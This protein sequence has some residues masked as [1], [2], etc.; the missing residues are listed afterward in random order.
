MNQ[1]KR[2][3]VALFSGGLDSSLAVATVRAQGVEVVAFHLVHYFASCTFDGAADPEVCAA[4]EELGVPLYTEEAT[5]AM[6]EMLRAPAHGF[7]KNLNPCIDCRIHTIRRADRFRREFGADFLISGEVLGQRPMSQNRQSLERIDRETGLAD[8]HLRP[9]SASF[10]APTLPEREGWIDRAALPAIQGRG[11]KEQLAMAKRFGISRYGSPAGGCHLTDR[12]FSNRLR[13][14]M[15]FR[16]GFG[17]DDV[18]L[19]RVGRHFA[20]GEDFRLVSGRDEEENGRLE[21]LARE[22][23]VLF[24]A[25]ERRGAIVLLRPRPG[26]PPEC[27]GRN[28]AEAAAAAAGLAVHYSRHRLDPGAV[29]ERRTPGVALGEGE[30]I[31]DVAAVDPA[32]LRNCSDA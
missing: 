15:A 13:D 24:Q 22:G 25:R 3:A 5:G 28:E 23:D 31:P 4:A 30:S 18:R 14:L 7:G 10:F 9:L 1:R 11:R 29:V 12:I 21:I 26:I 6:I 27:G 19:L 20:C 17:P 8:L 16:P 32:T 2:K